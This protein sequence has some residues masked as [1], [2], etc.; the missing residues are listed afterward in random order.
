M[1][2]LLNS[3]RNTESYK[4]IVGKLQSGERKI[5]L[6]GLFG[7]SKAY[8]LSALAKDLPATFLIVLPS[9]E[10][11]EKLVQDLLT[12]LEADTHRHDGCTPEE[13]ASSASEDVLLFP[14]WHGE[15]QAVSLDNS[16]LPS[17]KLVADR[18]LC[19]DKLLQRQAGE[20]TSFCIV[21]TSIKA[22]MHK[23]LPKEIFQ[24]SLLR[25]T[26][27]DEIDLDGTL[28]K[29]VHSGYRNVNM[30][31]MKGEFARRGDILDIYPLTYDNPVR[32]ELWGD[33]VDSIR[34]FDV[35]SQ[36]SIEKLTE[37]RILPVRELILTP[38]AIDNCR[39]KIEQ[40]ATENTSPKFLQALFAF[41][42]QLETFFPSWE[43]PGVGEGLEAYL[44]WFYPNLNTLCDYLPEDTIVFVDEFRWISR[45]ADG[46]WENIQKDYE[47]K[48]DLD[49]VVVVP[50][51]TF[52]DA[53]SI[54][55]ILQEKQMIYSALSGH[56]ANESGIDEPIA[57]LKD[58]PIEMGMRSIPAHRGNFQMFWDEFREWQKEG[59]LVN[60]L[61]DNAK[62]IE[63]M[64]FILEERRLNI[65]GIA[66]GIG[67]L[68]E[69]FISDELKLVM[70]SDDEIFGRQRQRQRRVKFKEGAPISSYIDLKESDYVVHV[71]HG[72]GI[73]RGIKRLDIDG[74]PQDFLM[75]QYAGSDVLYVPTYQIDMVQKYIGGGD[76]VK[77]KIDRLGGTRWSQLKARVKQDIQKLAQE[78]LELYAARAALPGHAF[79][80]NTPWQ[81][82]FEAAFPYEETPDQ[83]KAIEEALADMERPRPMDRLI[84]GDVGYG[85]TEVAMRAA[86]KA[87]MD[88]K[89]VAVLVPTTVLAQQHFLTFYER[90][91]PFP[92]KVGMLS[93]FRT[94]KEIKQLLEDLANGKVD[95]VIGT[96][97]LLSKDVKFHDL[98]L[99]VI[100]EEH[101][102][103][104][105]HKERIKQLRK[106]VDVM[107]M[108]ATPI[109]RTMHMSL[110]G[111][112]D[113]S[114]INTPPE[115]RLPIETY[116]MEFKPDIVRDAILKEMDRGGQVYF[117]H[118]RIESIASVANI[119]QELVPQA[120]IAVAHGQMHERQLERIMLD[121]IA[122]KYDV[123]VCTTIIESGLDIPNVNTIIINR[124]DALGL[125]QLYQLRGRVGRAQEQA[126]GYLLYP[127]ARTITEGAQKRLRVIEEFTD[128]SS[129]FKIALRDLEIRGVGNILGPEQH[130]H[131]VAVGYDMY[132]KLL[133]EAVKELKGEEVVEAVETKISF[134]IEAYLP[135]EYV[136]D[137]QQKVSL[138]KK[139][140]AL[141]T[142][143]E[144]SDLEEEMEDRYGEIPPPVHALLEIAE[145]KQFAQKLGINN[146]VSSGNVIKITF[147]HRKTDVNPRRL[148]S[149]IKQSKRLSLVP[150]VR[151][152]VDVKDLDEKQQ[153]ETV[154]QVLQQ[155]A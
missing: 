4:T 155:L 99:L 142:P 84:C 66:V 29:L 145:L 86:F 143:Q 75:L 107:T 50:H 129:G 16:A 34:L 52:K 81:Q 42:E 88:G 114:I 128:L 65:G 105:R 104:V 146:I 57:S 154:K 97:R 56:L 149:V 21:V 38:E 106:Q 76:D 121:F 116:V 102:F 80:R 60:I 9:Q 126:Y 70:M 3:L 47:K 89:Q 43:G 144:R 138:Y 93:R 36:R 137:S 139:I 15:K 115:N 22:L 20:P 87:V 23:V 125:A 67:I 83:L 31:E 124:A 74:R 98:G 119:V 32:V 49:Q 28:E 35:A 40:L 85:K 91:E 151:L 79:S 78:L 44:P 63:R 132:C 122:Y 130:G 37:V 131:I 19:L 48:F 150:P 148:V 12:F 8:L 24:S 103:G 112:R 73:Y 39:Q 5:Q 11:A 109:P 77:L 6:K 123:L 110:V 54:F 61:C 71:S 134:P 153:L 33:E 53:E 59:Y 69:G 25:L 127:E 7:S 101:R 152:M 2:N 100:D 111:A 108:S 147:D 64:N 41:K 13:M 141:T 30:V 94:P 96:H 18:M 136:P 14:E 117:V 133:N 92:V 27:G 140:A 113:L 62:Q 17:K 120:R 82:E 95:I 72:I 135:D 26:V 51:E 90:F 1:N 55:N 58:K 45:A 118:N 68:N 10:E 46:F